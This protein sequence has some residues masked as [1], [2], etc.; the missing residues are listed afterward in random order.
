MSSRQL[1][2]CG[3][4]PSTLRSVACEV[5]IVEAV[6]WRLAEVFCE[7]WVC[8]GNLWWSNLRMNGSLEGVDC[9]L[10][11]DVAGEEEEKGE[12]GNW[13]RVIKSNSDGSR[14]THQRWRR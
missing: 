3:F 5:F 10:L 2:V 8:S 13:R 14:N 1:H 12:C 6:A 9:L 7:N 4:R 11:E